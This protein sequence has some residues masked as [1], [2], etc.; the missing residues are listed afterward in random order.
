MALKVHHLNC[1]TMCPVCARLINGQGG[2]LEPAQMVCHVLLI[3]TPRDGLVLVDTGIGT[4]DIAD[5]VTAAGVAVDKSEVRLPNGPLRHT[6]EY[7]IAVQ[8]HSDVMAS[9]KVLVAAE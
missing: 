2:W 8:V 3:E 9:V 7:D 6:G 1:G 4:R 5:A